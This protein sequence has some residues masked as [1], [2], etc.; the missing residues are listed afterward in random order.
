VVL[1]T[2]RARR[3]RPAVGQLR[4]PHETGAGEPYGRSTLLPVTAAGCARAAS[5]EPHRPR[6][7]YRGV[8]GRPAD[9]L[10]A[11]AGRHRPV[12]Q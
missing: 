2:D 7:H 10:P 9:V 11:A 6:G 12:A 8:R 1:S 4:R 5:A 3:R